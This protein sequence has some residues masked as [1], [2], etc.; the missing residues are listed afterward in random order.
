MKMNKLITTALLALAG[1]ALLESSAMAQNFTSGDLLLNFRLTSGS[2]TTGSDLEVNLGLASAFNFSQTNQTLA[3]L[4]VSDLNTLY[5]A[6]GTWNSNANLVWSIVGAN[7]S[8]DL[9]LSD[10]S[11]TVLTT[12]IS[13]TTTPKATISALYTEA[14]S[15]QGANSSSFVVSPT[16]ANSYA[17]VIKNVNSLAGQYPTDYNFVAF[18]PTTEQGVSGS[19]TSIDLYEFTPATGKG[20][21]TPATITDLGTFVLGGNGVLTYDPQA[22]PEPSTYALFGLG[23]L[24]V[25]LMRRRA[26]KA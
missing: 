10:P 2:G 15:P 3:Q 23:A 17:S 5:G 16:D 19:G 1:A 21:S 7:S 6:G 9:F 12:P 13:S 18:E 26:I 11:A 4:N 8:N 25:V 20:G 14:G 24:V 22:V